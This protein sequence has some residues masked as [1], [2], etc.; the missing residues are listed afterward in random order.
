VAAAAGGELLASTAL[1]VDARL[2]LTRA[3]ELRGEAYQGELVRGL[4]G[5]GVGQNFGRPA[6]G[7]LLGAPVRDVAGWAQLTLRSGEGLVT[8]VGCGVDR[9]RDADRPLRRG[10]AACA[11]HLVWRPVQPLVLGAEFRR[12][13]TLYDSGWNRASH[14]NLALGFE[15]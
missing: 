5:G 11:V 2:R 10:N 1:A 15:L 13:G 14:L 7:A 6:P 3:L 9:N 12:L 4:G 8:G